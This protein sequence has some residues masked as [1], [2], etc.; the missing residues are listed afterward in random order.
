MLDRIL[1]DPLAFAE[2]QQALQGKV[3]LNELDERVWLSDLINL[4]EEV[5]YTLRGGRDVLGRWYLQLLVSGKLSLQ[6]QRCMNSVG[7]EL[8][9]DV[10]IVLFENEAKLD[11]AMLADEELEGMVLE[12]ELD[13]FTL[14]EDQ[15]LM[16]LPFSPKHDDCGNTDLARVNQD[17]TN[18]FAVLAG[19][20]KTV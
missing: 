6:C 3:S 9:E 4:K 8:G 7:F 17:K 5:S 14:L 2:K 19:V 11:E 13:V 1:I 18:P 15:I 16:A 10:R 12:K 20:K